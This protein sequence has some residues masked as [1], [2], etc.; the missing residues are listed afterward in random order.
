MLL[1]SIGWY[2][3]KQKIANMQIP[4]HIYK[5]IIYV[6]STSMLYIYNISAETVFICI[7]L[8]IYHEYVSLN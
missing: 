1:P 4:M 3:F 2:G 8:F 7:N 5:Y 6:K